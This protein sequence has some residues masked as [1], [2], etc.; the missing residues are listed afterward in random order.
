MSKLADKKSVVY[1]FGDFSGGVNINDPAISIPANQCQ[2][3]LNFQVLRQGLRRWPGALNVTALGDVTNYFRGQFRYTTTTGND[4]LLSC[5]GGKVYSVNKSTGAL[6]LIYDLGGSGE[7]WGSEH[8]GSFFITNGSDSC[9]IEGTTGYRI[10]I[11]APTA[12]SVAPA[13]GG[14]LPDGVYYV[15]VGYARQVSGL[16]VLYSK[17]YYAG[18]VTLGTGNNKVAITGFTNSSD[19]QVNNKVVWMTDAGGATYYFYGETGDN[20]TTAITISNDTDKN[21]SIIYD[22]YAA[23]NDLIPTIDCLFAFDNR[24]WGIKDNILYYSQ[25]STNNYELEKFP[26]LNKI[27]YPYKLT[28]I[29]AIGENLYLNTLTNGI[30]KQPA[31]NVGVRFEHKE[32]RYSFKYMRTVVDWNGGKFG[33]TNDGLMFFDGEKFQEFDYG[34]NIKPALKKIYSES[35]ENTQPCGIVVVRDNRVEYHLSFCDTALGTSNNNRTYVLNLSQTFFQDSQNYKTP[36]EILGRGFNYATVDTTGTLYM[37]QSHIDGSVIYKENSS[38]TT[39]IG[40]YDETG[41][42]LSTAEEMF[43]YINSKVIITDLFTKSIIENVRALVQLGS[44]AN[45]QVIIADD[46]STILSQDTDISSYG[47]AIWDSFVWDA[48]SPEQVRWVNEQESMTEIKGDQGMFGYSFYIKFSQT[49]DD[50]NFKYGEID[51]LVTLETGRGI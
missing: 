21:N 16:N 6:T 51:L 1:K 17:G 7:M 48:T 24:L 3:I 31:G 23:Y 37:S 35:G 18:S 28:G 47:G 38:N 42:Y 40:I 45:I 27:E 43:A 22:T 2:D 4:Y 15:Y 11:A 44:V 25:K 46:L 20:T 10:G 32:Q 9:K 39:E 5:F 19:A 26:V 50:I 49:A 12:A 13:S 33:I 29:F 8:F 41:A 34:Y 14:S 30:I 36:W